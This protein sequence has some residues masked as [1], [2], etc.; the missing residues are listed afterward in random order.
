MKTRAA[1]LGA[2][3]AIVACSPP[4]PRDPTLA[5][6]KR[7]WRT[8]AAQLAEREAAIARLAEARGTVMALIRGLDLE[9]RVTTTSYPTED[10]QR[11]CPAAARAVRQPVALE[12]DA[13]PPDRPAQHARRLASALFMLDGEL[14]RA[15]RG[16]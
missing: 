15:G 11:W 8:L 3:L 16:T 12:A 5:E 9:V 14:G 4:P 1:A 13:A 10:V 6:S 2:A 7:L